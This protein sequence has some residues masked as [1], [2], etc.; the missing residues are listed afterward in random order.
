MKE[1]VSLKSVDDYTVTEQ[2][3]LQAVTGVSGVIGEEGHLTFV[4]QDCAEYERN[5]YLRAVGLKIPYSR[6]RFQ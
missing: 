4:T 3:C 5:F 1:R 6:F 2:K